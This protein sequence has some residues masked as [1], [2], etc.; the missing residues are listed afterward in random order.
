MTE[1]KEKINAW[2][3]ARIE[4]NDLSMGVSNDFHIAVEE[5]ATLIRLGEAIFGPRG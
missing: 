2:K 4:I 5:G 3:L 1:W